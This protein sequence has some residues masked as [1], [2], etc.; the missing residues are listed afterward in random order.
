VY[1]KEKENMRKLTKIAKSMK[2]FCGLCAMLAVCILAASFTGCETSSGSSS[3][4]TISITPSSVTLTA[5]AISAVQFSAAGGNNS[6]TWSVS[7]PSLGTISAATNGL[8]ATYQ[9][10]TNAGVNVVIVTDT[11]SASATATVTQQ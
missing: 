3:S 10:T 5:G 6:F 8:T 9:S 1:W 4:S 7:T 11:S 2:E